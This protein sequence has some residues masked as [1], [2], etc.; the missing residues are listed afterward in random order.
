M[1]TNRIKI[2]IASLVGLLI[3]LIACNSSSP[4]VQKSPN[5][6][7]F[8]QIPYPLLSDYGFFI[9][10]MKDLVANERVLLYE[11][12]STLFTDY[13]EKSRF[14]WMAEGASA[15][16]MDNTWQEIDFPDKSVLI[17][18]FYYPDAD[19][20][21]RIVETRL[22][23][24]H[25]GKW[26]AYPYLW[27]EDQ[28]D[29]VYKMTGAMLPLA[30]TDSYGRHHEIDYLQ[31]NKNQCK[32]C[33]NQNEEFKPIG[34]K[35]RNLNW[36]LDYGNGELKNQLQKWQE[37]GYLN[38]FTAAENYQSIPSYKHEDVDLN[39][40]ARAYLDA[41]CAYC[42]NPLGPG[43]TSGL[44]LSYEV[45][46][47]SQLGYFKT[48]VAAGLGAGPHTFDIYPSKADSSII[49]YRMNSSEAGVMMPELG[50]V[51]IDQ[52]GLDLV[53]AWINA[54]K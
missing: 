49:V 1:L 9:G 21:S 34:P 28:K 15:S 38:N 22:L 37:M 6:I 12:S 51:M 30:F 3:F 27:N 7:D 54:M 18:N 2:S 47:S 25:E 29:A 5:D 31:P 53:S 46:D 13:A 36:D 43:S 16:I 19:G 32:S 23:V 10:E 20:G 40:R 4:L 24:K 42:H 45:S 48:P 11:P 26:N 50:R 39:F 35:A 14:V 52:E 8:A 17:K 44:M 41:N 33:H